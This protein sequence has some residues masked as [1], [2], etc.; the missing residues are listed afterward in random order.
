MSAALSAVLLIF[1]MSV[2]KAA[3]RR[4]GLRNIGHRTLPKMWVCTFFC[5]RRTIQGND[6]KLIL[7]VKMV[8]H[9]TDNLVVS[10]R[11]L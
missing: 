5:T 11:D 7:A 3:H 10:F 4:I 6:F 9:P 2:R 8:R 1:S